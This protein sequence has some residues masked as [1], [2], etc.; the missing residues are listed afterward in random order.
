MKKVTFLF[1]LFMWMSVPT[2]QTMNEVGWISKFGLAGGFTPMWFS[3]SIDELNSQ[4]AS[5]GVPA[6][7]ENGIITYGGGGYAYIMFLD[8]VRLGGIGFS[9]SSSSN[10]VVNGFNREVEYSIGGGAVTVEYTIPSI[11]NIALSLG[12]MLGAGSFDIDI[13]QN[14]GDVNWGDL[15]NEFSGSTENITRKLSNKYF[16][17][18]PTLNFDIPLNRFIAL[19]VGCGYQFTFSN[20]WELDNE[21]SLHGIP[22]G[23][24]ADSFFIQTG[25]FAGFFAF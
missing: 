20:K 8:N 11:K 25:L 5:F 22:S 7:S 16:I 13:Y 14:Q 1:I 19:R 24:N 21:Q 15:W 6:F 18:A 17:F 3:P 23:L 4:L 10:A 12:V 2:A 9:G